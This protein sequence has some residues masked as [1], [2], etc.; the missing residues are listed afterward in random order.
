M[1][2][3]QGKKEAEKI[4]SDLKKKIKEAKLR[5][6]LA[7]ILIG[8][9]P[10]SKLY[11][12]IKSEAATRVGI[13][14]VL[15]KFSVRLNE[16]KIIGEIGSLN[17]RE[18]IHGILVQLPLPKGYDTDKI[19][20]AIDSKKNVD[21]G[22]L[23]SAIYIALKQG[24]K[25]I[26]KKN[27]TA[28]VNSDFFGEVLKR[29]F[30]EKKIKINYILRRF[31]SSAKIKKADA[32][33]VACGCHKLIKGDMIKKGAVLIDAGVPADVDENSVKNKAGFLTPVPGGIGP[34]TV[35]LLLKN[36]YK[37]AY[38]NSKINRSY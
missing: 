37:K 14:M 11:I 34:L 28:V 35:A 6:G 32:L 16:D 3:F 12:K 29:F 22:V 4:L 31:F 26:K 20:R 13:R 36:I 9:D 1:R 8:E 5:P 15:R 19:I 33:I 24:L 10:A 23:P 21:K 27:I 38:G 7:V 2:L 18:D 30:H 25:N 17:K